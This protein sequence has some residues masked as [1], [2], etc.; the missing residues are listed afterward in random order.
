M[1]IMENPD[2]ERDDPEGAC[3]HQQQQQHLPQQQQQQQQ[4]QQSQWC[5]NVISVSAAMAT[6]AAPHNALRLV[7]KRRAC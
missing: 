1:M 5:A 6:A 2:A 4:Q 7:F 3:E